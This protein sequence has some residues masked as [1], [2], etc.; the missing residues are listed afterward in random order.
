LIQQNLW[1]KLQ[2]RKYRHSFVGSQIAASVAAQIASTRAARGWTQGKLAKHAKMS[3]VRISVLEDPS[4]ENFSIKTLKRLAEALDVALIVRF[5]PFS[6]MLGWLSTLGPNK[7]AVPRFTE[8][9]LPNAVENAVPIAAKDT[10]SIAAE[11]ASR[12]IPFSPGAAAIPMQ[13]DRLI[14]ERLSQLT[15]GAEASAIGTSSQREPSNVAS[16][17]IPSRGQQAMIG[18]IQ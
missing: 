17:Q 18:S 8:D 4:Y 1:K 2:S 11:D 10:L 15:A 7:L 3:Q 12:P 5:A 6:E 13:W 9:V 14:K 16:Y